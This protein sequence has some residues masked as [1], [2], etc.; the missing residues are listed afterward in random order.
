MSRCLFGAHKAKRLHRL[1]GRSQYTVHTR[2]AFTG[3]AAEAQVPDQLKLHPDVAKNE[4]GY[5]SA[6]A[7]LSWMPLVYVPL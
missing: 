7:P 4:V 6:A 2:R 3:A 1:P 5:Q